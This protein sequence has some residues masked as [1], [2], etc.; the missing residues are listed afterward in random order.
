MT[1]VHAYT[2]SDSTSGSSLFDSI[3]ENAEQAV[4]TN[5]IALLRSADK[6][7]R[8]TMYADFAHLC[9][10]YITSVPDM[11]EKALAGLIAH[12]V[13]GDDI[14]A[15][16]V[17]TGL[18]A[19]SDAGGYALES[20]LGQFR[21]FGTAIG[22]PPG[23]PRLMEAE[24]LIKKSKNRMLNLTSSGR[25]GVAVGALMLADYIWSALIDHL[26]IILRDEPI[27]RPVDIAFFAVERVWTD[28][29]RR[30][31]DL[32]YK[33]TVQPNIERSIQFGAEQAMVAQMEI[34]DLLES[35]AQMIGYEH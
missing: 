35:R 30:L 2:I 24:M 1:H 11:F 13:Q 22:R 21:R 18:T 32:A 28:N 20:A 3:C 31:F 16:L 25:F 10:P 34:F 8:Q 29:G 19:K 9:D 17:A 33:Q 12:G 6:N 15:L 5:Y 23:L 7:H 26:G 4:P 14:S 27:V